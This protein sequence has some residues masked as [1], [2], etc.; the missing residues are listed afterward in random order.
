M[1]RLHSSPVTDGV[2]V[3]TNLAAGKYSLEGARR[4]F[5]TSAYDA[6]E[7]YSTA[8]VTGGEADSEHLV[9]RLTPQAVLTGR[10]LDEAGDPVRRANVSLLPPGPKHG[11]GSGGKDCQCSHRRPRYLRIR[12]IASGKLLHLGQRPALVCAASALVSEWGRDCYDH[13]QRRNRNLCD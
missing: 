3:F 10:V 6:H 9:F 13:E 2:F 1:K 5:I 12:R 4:G 7:Q 11:R 8:I